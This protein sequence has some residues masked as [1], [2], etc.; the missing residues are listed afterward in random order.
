M[1]SKNTV[2]TVALLLLLIGSF[3]SFRVYAGDST[4]FEIPGKVSAKIF[5]N[6]HT[7]INKGDNP[8]AFEITRAYFGYENKFSKHFEAAVKL[9]I[10]SP[11]DLSDF[12]KI[13]RYA[14]FKNA[15]LKFN[16]NKITSLFGIIDLLHFKLQENFWSRRYIEKSFS[17]RYRLGNSADLGWLINY[18]WEK[19]LSADFTI[20]N[21]EGY[22]NLQTD[23]TLKA[24][25]GIT[26]N[27]VK[28]LV[29]RVYYD[30]T[31]KS[32]S[33]STLATFIGY[34][35]KGAYSAGI[36]YNYRFNDNHQKGYNK[37]GYSIYGS[38]NVFEKVQLFGRYDR[39]SSNI[40]DDQ[41]VPWNLASDGSSII[42]GIE[43]TPI[44]NIRIAVDYQ[45]WF[46]YAENTENQQLI[47]LNLEIS[48]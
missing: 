45:D 29:T 33:Q 11:E 25:A 34:Q 28:N 18:E 15:Y 39:L 5:S 10:G 12:S 7:Y 38:Y 46:P 16:Y 22:S 48:F 26:V 36:E 47:Y 41:S 35:K 1:K 24:G 3:L 30:F 21:G 20:M 43:Y 4:R 23:N 27:P 14:Y 37:Y 31:E 13:R 2:F 9:D 40:P 17:D 19:W 8:L 44:K 42:G 32:T 6:F